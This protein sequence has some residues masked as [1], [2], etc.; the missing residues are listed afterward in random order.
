M[1]ELNTVREVLVAKLS[2]EID[3]KVAGEL[4][5]ALERALDNSSVR[6]LVFD[7]TGVSFIDSTGLGVILGRYKRVAS[8]GGKLGVL[9][10]SPS[11]RRV[12]ELSGVLRVAQE[13]DSLSE[14]VN[15][16]G[17]GEAGA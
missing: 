7:F 4:R 5:R 17:G 1:L 2:G 9:G 16:F 14:A 12:L 8:I 6:H 13:F 3:L 11:V 10:M 15:A